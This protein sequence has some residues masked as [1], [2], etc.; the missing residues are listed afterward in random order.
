MDCLSFS[1][2]VFVRAI[3]FPS[4]VLIITKVMVAMIYSSKKEGKDKWQSILGYFAK[5]L[6]I[7]GQVS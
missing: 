3:V 1:I 4:Y 6:R 5:Y 2:L 7:L